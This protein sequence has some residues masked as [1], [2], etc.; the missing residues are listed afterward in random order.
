M[1]MVTLQRSPRRVTFRVIKVGCYVIVDDGVN[2]VT[3]HELNVCI[4]TKAQLDSVSNR[5]L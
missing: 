5:E 3:F 2:Y 4:K 1:G